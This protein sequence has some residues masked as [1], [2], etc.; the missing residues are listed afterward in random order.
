[1]D[2]TDKIKLYSEAVD[3]NFA[4]A[5]A[6]IETLLKAGWH[7]DQVID[8]I[9]AI[10]KDNPNYTESSI[11]DW[12]WGD[13]EV[14]QE[15]Q[16]THA[17][18]RPIA[19]EIKRFISCLESPDIY[20]SEVYEELKIISAGDK[21][22]AQVAFHRLSNKDGLL[23]KV[24]RGHFR[25]KAPSCPNID[26]YSTNG[27]AIDFKYPLGI[28][29]F[30][31]T[32]PKSICIVAGEPDAGKT[33]WLLNCAA[34]NMDNYNIYYFSSEMGG[35]ELRNRLSKFK[36][37]L[38]A[39]RKVY[40]K[41]RSSNFADVIEPDDVNIIDF[42]EV[43]DEFYKVGGLIKDIHDKLNKGIALIA[44]QKNPGRDWGLG[45]MRS[46]E[47]ARLYLAMERTGQMKIVK[48]KNWRNETVNPNGLSIRYRLGGGCHFKVE[49]EWAKEG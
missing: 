21:A 46:I 4:I 45:G 25:I 49:S 9:I 14:F 34:K 38:E 26:I 32:F 44:L 3:K 41:E 39:W 29:E 36:V 27:M 17:T 42:L 24:G 1:M 30:Y 43:H 31:I 10:T 6:T 22:A 5:Q 19:N 20:L 18:H 28:H 37:P 2:N 35:I 16:I 47:K 7:P 23:Q 48:A 12:V 8:V 15:L 13:Y 33:A 11:H 40:W